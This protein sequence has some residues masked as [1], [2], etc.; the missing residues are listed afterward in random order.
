MVQSNRPLIRCRLPG[1]QLS[2]QTA[3]SPV[4]CASET[5]KLPWA[6]N[7]PEEQEKRES[8]NGRR[9][10][11][12]GLK[13]KALKLVPLQECPMANIPLHPDLLQSF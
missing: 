9:N 1:P 10:R 2:A 4:R 7:E 13:E 5:Q 6:G 3:S 11:T 8:S 12:I